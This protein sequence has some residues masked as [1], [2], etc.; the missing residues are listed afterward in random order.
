MITLAIDTGNKQIKT[1]HHTFISGIIPQDTIPSMVGQTEY[2][3][4]NGKYY[5]LTNRRDKYQRD[6]SE[7]D[8]YFL[9]SLMGIVK[10]LEHCVDN[11]SLEY[12]KNKVYN[13]NLLCGLPPA[14]MSDAAVKKNFRSYFKTPEPVK[15]QYCGRT[16]QIKITKTCVYAQCYSAIMTVFSQVKDYINVLGVDIGGFTMDYLLLRKGNIDMDYTD[17][18]ENGVILLYNKISKECRKK[19]NAIIN[20]MDVDEILKNNTNFYEKEIVD[21]VHEIAARYVEQMLATF[22]EEQIDLEHTFVVFM[23]GGSLL[24]RE[25]IE[26]STLLKNYMFIDSVTANVEGY[27]FLYQVSQRSAGRK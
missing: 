2:F 7:S 21:T 20:E 11:G 3:K 10:E 25:F 6:K 18:L 9:L 26:K 23:G 24:L 5:V 17:S 27:E 1:K 16:W 13:I 12:Q 4:Y 22:R 14:H 8:Q 19:Y 15:V